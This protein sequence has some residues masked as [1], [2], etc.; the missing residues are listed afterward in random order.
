[1]RPLLDISSS[2]SSFVDKELEEA[3]NEF[4]FRS[5]AAKR[6]DRE[7][8]DAVK[9]IKSLRINI[10]E[11]AA[12]DIVNLAQISELRD[13]A[14]K[15]SHKASVS[16]SRL[17]E[18]QHESIMHSTQKRAAEVEKQGRSSRCTHYVQKAW[19]AY[20]DCSHIR[21]SA[22]KKAREL[23]MLKLS[24]ALDKFDKHTMMVHLIDSGFLG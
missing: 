1:M 15:I 12:D 10:G 3:V 23:R 20:T 22:I 2:D 16:A 7:V 14:I 19:A 24:D 8:K 9:A 21:L 13:Q 11:L 5:E 17:W 18:K 4:P 6:C